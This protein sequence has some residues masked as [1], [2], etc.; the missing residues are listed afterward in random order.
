M[1]LGTKR[2]HTLPKAIVCNLVADLARLLRA[3]AQTSPA[4]PPTP[5]ANSTIPQTRRWIQA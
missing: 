1:A 5:R 4:G 3:R 2:T